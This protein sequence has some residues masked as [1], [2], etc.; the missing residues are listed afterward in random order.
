[1]GVDAV[2]VERTFSEQA[3]G[4]LAQGKRHVQVTDQAAGMC[5]LEEV[6]DGPASSSGVNQPP[7]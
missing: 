5:P 2:A 3:L 6:A 7:V 1:M 4:F